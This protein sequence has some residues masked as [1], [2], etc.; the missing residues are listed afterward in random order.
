MKP[1]LAVNVATNNIRYPIYASPKLDGVRGL[2]I[3]GQLRSRTLKPIPNGFV[4]ARFSRPELNGFDGELIFGPPNASDVFRATTSAV[5]NE[6][7]TPNVHFYVFDNFAASG[8]FSDR[9][10]TLNQFRD[11]VT[12]VEQ[13]LIEN[14]RDLLAYESEVLTAGYEGLILRDP[15]GPYKHGRSTEREGW[16]LKLKRFVD[17]EAEILDIVE[18]MENTNEATRNAVGRTERSSAK[19]GLR[20]KG[21]AGSLA[22]RDIRTGVQF[23]IGSGLNSSD[24]ARFWAYRAQ[25]I[26]KII[27]YKSFQI[28][29]KDAP[30][31]PV[32]LGFRAGFDLDR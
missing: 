9:L 5:S 28:G 1:M 8:P 13:R 24:R 12:V 14:E 7:F 32:Y 17:S 10:K 25:L 21:T 23:S 3:N 16:M 6:S 30:R 22:V 29:V 19:A 27:K 31:F 26:G 2:V 4:S 11:G 15:R 20:P 18:E